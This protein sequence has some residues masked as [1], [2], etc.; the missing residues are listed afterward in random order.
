MFV[1][2]SLLDIHILNSA[3]RV[4]FDVEPSLLLSMWPS[5]K[6]RVLS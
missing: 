3:A 6:G 2:F 1:R 4:A 5:V